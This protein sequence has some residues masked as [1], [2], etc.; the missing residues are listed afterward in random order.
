MS[1]KLAD[2]NNLSVG[3]KLPETEIIVTE[4]VIE[5]Y[6]HGSG[7]YNSVHG[8]SYQNR[9]LADRTPEFLESIKGNIFGEVVA[10]GMLGMGL[11]GKM[12][13]TNFGVDWF[14]K[15]CELST[16]FRNPIPVDSKVVVAGEVTGKNDSGITVRGECRLLGGDV[17]VAVTLV[18]NHGG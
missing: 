17:A 13:T 6:G 8:L 2:L 12:F 18:V 4:K 14:S 9:G 5:N 3:D 1:D 11:I 10:H 7:D 15:S 16:Q